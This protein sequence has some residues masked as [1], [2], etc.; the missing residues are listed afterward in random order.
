MH[1]QTLHQLVAEEEVH[2]SQA[3][4]Q[5]QMETMVVLAVEQE[6]LI[7]VAH[8][9]LVDQAILQQQHHLKE[10]MA[11]LRLLQVLLE[12]W[13]AAAAQ[14][15]MVQMQTQA[16]AVVLV[17]MELHQLFLEL[18]LLMQVVG[19]VVVIPDIQQILILV[20]LVEQVAEEMAPFEHQ[21]HL[22]ME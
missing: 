12:L 18:V 21:V 6:Y 3:R 13:V 7:L 4:H 10:I 9:A 15:L 11:E 17:V 22:M 19:V 2:I 8:Q 1:Q 20:E 14:V 5:S 16:L